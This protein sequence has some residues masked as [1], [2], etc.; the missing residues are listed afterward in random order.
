DFASRF[1][2]LR[3]DIR[4]HGASDAP[5]GEYS[6]ES[7]GREALRLLDALEIDRVAWCGASLGGMIGQWIAIHAP[8]R[9]SALVLANTSPRIA[10][11]AGMETRRTTVLAQGVGAVVDAA[12]SRFFSPATLAADLPRIASARETFL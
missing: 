5:P 4:G 6:I 1:R 11:P 8:D 9:L 12:M 10:D 2:V 3:Y 7:L